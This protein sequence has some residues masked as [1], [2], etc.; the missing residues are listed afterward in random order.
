MDR[1]RRIII[2]ISLLF[3]FSI[4]IVC[5]IKINIINSETLSPINYEY[6]GTEEEDLLVEY[7]DFIRDN[8][9][10]K[11]YNNEDNFLFKVG[12]KEYIICKDISLHSIIKNIFDKIEEIL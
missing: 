12:D 2:H 6:V 9:F 8:T 7:Q 3:I 4:V 5:L 11:I 10:I 1:F